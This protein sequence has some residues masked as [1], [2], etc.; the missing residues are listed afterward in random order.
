MAIN[1]YRLLG[2][3][4]DADDRRLKAAYRSLAKRFHPDLNPGCEASAALFQKINDAY[5][6]LADPQARAAY[7][8]AQAGNLPAG[9]ANGGRAAAEGDPAEKF[10]RFV[11]SLLDA[12]FGPLEPP[13]RPPPEVRPRRPARRPQGR[14]RPDFSFYFHLEREKDTAT[15]AQ[16]EDGIYRPQTDRKGPRPTSRGARKG[17]LARSWLVALLASLWHLCQ[18]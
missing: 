10:N 17:P 1:H 15:Y 7:D 12:L 6:V 3:P 2:V 11:N 9:P 16:G 18:P 4:P 14:S 5:R 8:A 13:P